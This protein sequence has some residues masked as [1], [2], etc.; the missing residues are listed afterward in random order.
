MGGQTEALA[1]AIGPIGLVRPKIFVMCPFLPKNKNAK[2]LYITCA[3]ILTMNAFSMFL[4]S[5]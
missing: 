2:I 1:Y 5:D 3:K 4:L